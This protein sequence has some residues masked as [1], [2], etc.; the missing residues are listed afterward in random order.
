[1]NIVTRPGPAGPDHD[2]EAAHV[3]ALGVALGPGPD[4]ERLDDAKPAAA[5]AARRGPR[6]SAAVLRS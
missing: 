2:G 4:A 3:E 6:G 5:P 1:M